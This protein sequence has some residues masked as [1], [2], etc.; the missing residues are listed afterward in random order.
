MGFLDSILKKLG[1]KEDNKQEENAE[2]EDSSSNNQE[3]EDNIQ[4]V[5]IGKG[6]MFEDEEEQIK[7]GA[8]QLLEIGR[9]KDMNDAIATIGTMFR[10]LRYRGTE[11]TEDGKTVITFEDVVSIKNRKEQRE[12]SDLQNGKERTQLDDD[13]ENGRE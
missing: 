11:V 6:E 7:V 8:K 1:A 5:I 13:M 12:N 10:G 3:K 9:A 4:I 2:T